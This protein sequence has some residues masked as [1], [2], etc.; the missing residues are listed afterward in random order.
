M[1]V[2][3]TLKEN[4]SIA[5]QSIGGNRLRTSLTALIIAIGIMALVGILTAIE[6]IR[7]YTND[8]FAGLGANTFTIQNRGSGI[9][10]GKGGHRKIYPVITYEQADR[11]IKL[12]KMPVRSSVDVTVSGTAIAKYNSVK[13]NP[14][15]RVIGSN[16]N[17]VAIKGHTIAFGRN[18]SSSELEHG[19][20]V[21]IIGDDLKQQLFKKDDAINKTI[22]LG[23][24]KFRVI[25]VL[26]SKGANSF[27][28]DKFCIIPVLKARQIAATSKPTFSITIAVSGPGA[29]DATTGEA[30]SLFRNVRGLRIG[31]PDNFEIFRS[32]SIQEELTGQLNNVTVAGFAIGIITLLGAA[33][34]LMNIM[35]VSVTE[36]TREI[37]LRKSIGATPAVI[38]K[39]FLIEA[40]VICLL[41]GI[42]GMILGMAVGNLIAV[43]ISGTFVVPWL[44]LFA[45][46]ALCTAIGLL[47]GFYPAKKAAG[48]DPVEALRY[49]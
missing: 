21:V 5:L 39:Q 8:A 12:F 47:S 18:F 2:K 9:S 13:T 17:Y 14:N 49:E 11:F 24:N 36:R 48:L 7:Q 16:D 22:L 41:G 3:T 45:A 20:N 23:S 30:T 35:L 31:Q 25:G 44:W 46:V 15:L 28:G 10:F 38:R 26:A 42:A 37:G 43:Q 1:A 29:L 27:G 6:G 19:A 40:I 32:D 33:I 4:I 34:G